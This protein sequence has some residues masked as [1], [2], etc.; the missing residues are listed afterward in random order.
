[1]PDPTTRLGHSIDIARE[2]VRWARRHGQCPAAILK[3]VGELVAP[4][5]PTW[6]DAVGGV[7]RQWREIQS[8]EFR[9]A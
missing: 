3:S 9:D 2:H 5:E 8:P 7:A 6:D 1:M 4:R